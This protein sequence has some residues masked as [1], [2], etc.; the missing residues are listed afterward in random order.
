MKLVGCERFGCGK[1]PVYRPDG[2]LCTTLTGYMRMPRMPD[3]FLDCSIYLYPSEGAAQR[4]EKLGGSGFLIHVNFVDAPNRHHVYA[5]TNA[6]VIQGQNLVVRLNTVDGGTDTVDGSSLWRCNETDDL[7]ILRIP[8]DKQ[9]HKWKAINRIWFLTQ[10]DI[11]SEG[12]GPGDDTFV[13][14]R[15][16]NHEGAQKNLP[17]LRFGTIG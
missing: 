14:G 9:H 2:S 13:V 17:T 8:L 5:V 6:H 1:A 11:P 4:G 7:A 12:I 3:A 10:N 15:F 16:I